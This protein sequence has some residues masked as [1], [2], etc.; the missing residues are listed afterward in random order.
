MTLAIKRA[1]TELMAATGVSQSESASLMAAKAQKLLAAMV[2]PSVTHT[3]SEC[4]ASCKVR[5]S[6]RFVESGR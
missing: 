6:Q 1:A 2:E 4:D 5:I 3:M